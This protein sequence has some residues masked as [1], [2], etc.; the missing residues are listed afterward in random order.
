MK[1]AAATHF[2]NWNI[3][4]ACDADIP[5][6]EALIPQSVR[7]LQ[8]AD[9]SE[10]QMEAALGS[11]FGS[12]DSSFAMGLTSWSNTTAP[13]SVAAAGADGGNVLA[14][15]PSPKAKINYSIRSTIRHVFEH[16]LSIRNSHVAGLLAQSSLACEGAIS[17]ENFAAAEMVA[18]LSGEPFYAA[19]GYSAC[20]R[21][22]VPL[23]SNLTLPVVRMTK[24]LRTG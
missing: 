2:P 15:M 14:A 21:D 5:A 18:T 19:F 17:A 3:R 23:T 24:Q 22:Q 12:I 11:V 16:S 13:L 6:L 1:E 4:L 20:E 8:R 10:E 9:Y 7:E